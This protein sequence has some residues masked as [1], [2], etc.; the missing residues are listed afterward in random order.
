MA[1]VKVAV[2]VRPLSKKEEETEAAFILDVNENVLSIVNLKV[3]GP[4]TEGDRNRQRVRNFTFDYCYLSA[5]KSR[6]D[7]ASQE[8][9]YQDLGTEILDASFAGYNACLFAYGQTGSGKTYTMMG[10]KDDLGLIPRICDGL[11]S[12][13]DDFAEDI[14]CQIEVSY[15]EIYNERV[16]D[17]L[18]PEDLSQYTLKVRE[19]PKDGPYVQDLSKHLVG[20]HTSVRDLIERGNVNRTTA[21]THMHDASSRSHAIFTINF[22]QARL[23]DNMPSEVVSKINLVDLA[24]SE[25]ADPNYSKGRLTE[26]ANINKSLVTLGNCISALGSNELLKASNSLSAAS[27]ESLAMAEENYTASGLPR[28]PGYIPYRNSV[29]TWLLKDSLGGNSKTIMISTVSPSSTYFNETMS[30]LRY[31]RRAKHIVNKPK[32]NEDQNVRLIRE[33]RAEIDSLKALLSCASLSSSQASLFQDKNINEILHENEQKVDRLTEAWVEK[34]REAASIMQECNVGIRR[35]NV[36]VIVESDLPHL[37]GMDDDL[38]STGIILY[39][40]KEG[41]TT[42]GRE[43]ADEEQD[44]VLCGPAIEQK[45]CTIENN[46][47]TVTLCPCEGALSAVN[48][49][50]VNQPIQLTQGAVV[51]FGKTNMYRFNHP[52]QAAKLRERR[53]SIQSNPEQRVTRKNS[54]TLKVPSSALNEESRQRSMSF[55]FTRDGNLIEEK[56]HNS[57]ADASFNNFDSALSPIMMYNSGDDVYMEVYENLGLERQ[58]KI[59]VEKLDETRKKLAELQE[60]QR[61]AEE[62]HQ[63]R[64][65]K[66]RRIY[67]SHQEMIEKQKK[68]LERLRSEHAQAKEEAEKDLKR[69]REMLLEEKAKGEAKLKEELQILK[70][71]LTKKAMTSAIDACVLPKVVAMDSEMSQHLTELDVDRKRV[72]QLELLYTQSQKAAAAQLHEK[73][74]T[75]ERKQDEQS[76]AIACAE[77][78]LADIENITF[79]WQRFSSRNSLE[80][81]VEEIGSFSGESSCSN[82]DRV[83]PIGGRSDSD[84]NSG[85]LLNVNNCNNSNKPLPSGNSKI[86]E[87]HTSSPGQNSKYHKKQN[88]K[89]TERNARMPVKNQSTPVKN[90]RTLKKSDQQIS[91]KLNLATGVKKDNVRKLSP[92]RLKSSLHDRKSPSPPIKRTSPNV[93][94]KNIRST[95]PNEKLAMSRSKSN[96]S[97][98]NSKTGKQDSVF[99]RLYKSQTPKF[100]YLKKKDRPLY[101]RDW[102][103]P[104]DRSQEYHQ[105]QLRKGL[106]P[107]NTTPSPVG[108]RQSLSPERRTPEINSAP[109]KFNCPPKISENTSTTSKSIPSSKVGSNSP[110]TPRNKHSSKTSPSYDARKFSKSSKD[111]RNKHIVTERNPITSPS[112]AV[113]SS[114]NNELKTESKTRRKQI[115]VSP[116]KKVCVDYVKPKIT[117]PKAITPLNM[118][119]RKKKHSESFYVSMK[120][121]LLKSIPKGINPV[122]CSDY[123]ETERQPA[124]GCSK[125]MEDVTLQGLQVPYSDGSDEHDFKEEQNVPSGESSVVDDFPD[126]LDN[127]EELYEEPDAN[128][129]TEAFSYDDGNESKYLNGENM[130]VNGMESDISCDSLDNEDTIL[131][132]DNTIVTI[133]PSNLTSP[134][135]KTVDPCEFQNNFDI[136]GAILDIP[137]DNALIHP[138]SVNHAIQDNAVGIEDISMDLVIHEDLKRKS[139]LEHCGGSESDDESTSENT[140]PAKKLRKRQKKCRRSES[141]CQSSDTENEERFDRNLNKLTKKEMEIQGEKDNSSESSSDTSVK[142]SD[143]GIHSDLEGSLNLSGVGGHLSDSFNCDLLVTKDVLSSEDI[144]PLNEDKP[145]LTSKETPHDTEQLNENMEKNDNEETC[146]KLTNSPSLVVNMIQ[147]KQGADTCEDQYTED[148]DSDSSSGDSMEGADYYVNAGVL[149]NRPLAD[150]KEEVQSSENDNT[151]DTT[152][153]TSPFS[154]AD[155]DSPDENK[156]YN[157]HDKRIDV[158]ECSSTDASE[159]LISEGVDI[160]STESSSTEEDC[161][162]NDPVEQ[163]SAIDQQPNIVTSS[164]LLTEQNEIENN[165]DSEIEKNC[166]TESD[167]AQLVIGVVDNHHALENNPKHILDAENNFDIVNKLE[168]AIEPLSELEFNSTTDDQKK[169]SLNLQN[170]EHAPAQNDLQLNENDSSMSKEPV[171]DVFEPGQSSEDVEYASVLNPQKKLL[172]VGLQNSSNESESVDELPCIEFRLIGQNYAIANAQLKMISLLLGTKSTIYSS[173]ESSSPERM[174]SPR[175]VPTPPEKNISAVLKENHNPYKG[176]FVD[177]IT[178]TAVQAETVKANNLPQ[179]LALISTIDTAQNPVMSHVVPV[180]HNIGDVI[181]SADMIDSGQPDFI[182]DQPGIVENFDPAFNI[183]EDS[184]DGTRFPPDGT[185]DVYSENS[186]KITKVSTFEI[187]T[188]TEEE[189]NFQGLCTSANEKQLPEN[190]PSKIDYGIK[191]SYGTQTELIP[192]DKSTDIIDA[193]PEFVTD[194]RDVADPGVSVEIQTDL[195][196]NKVGISVPD[197]DKT[198]NSLCDK[199]IKNVL[200]LMVSVATL[201]TMDNSNDVKH[202]G[203]FTECNDLYQQQPSKSVCDT[204]TSTDSVNDSREK[205]ANTRS[206]E[207]MLLENQMKDAETQYENSFQNCT[208]IYETI[209]QPGDVHVLTN[210]DHVPDIDRSNDNLHQSLKPVD[211]NIQQKVPESKENDILPLKESVAMSTQTDNDLKQSAVCQTD[212]SGPSPLDESKSPH[213]LSIHQLSMG[214]QTDNDQNMLQYEE[215]SLLLLNPSN[216][217]DLKTPTYS[218]SGIQVDDLKDLISVGTSYQNG[219]LSNNDIS[220]LIDQEIQTD[221]IPSEVNVDINDQT[222]K[223]SL[224]ES[225][226]EEEF[227]GGESDNTSDYQPLEGDSEDSP[228]KS[229]DASLENDDLMFLERIKEMK[230]KAQQVASR[231]QRLTSDLR[232]SNMTDS[233]D[234][235]DHSAEDNPEEDEELKTG[236][237][238]AQERIT[239]SDSEIP[240]TGSKEGEDTKVSKLGFIR[241]NKMDKQVV[242]TQLPELI[243]TDNELLERNLSVLTPA[244]KTNIDIPSQCEQLEDSIGQCSNKDESDKGNR[245]SRKKVDKSLSAECQIEDLQETNDILLDNSEKDADTAALEFAKFK[246][247]L[248]EQYVQQNMVLSE[249]KSFYQQLKEEQEE[250]EQLSKS[251]SDKKQFLLGIE[252]LPDTAEVT[253]RHKGDVGNHEITR[254][255]NEL[256]II[257]SGNISMDFEEET[258]A[259]LSENKETDEGTKCHMNPIKEEELACETIDT[260]KVISHAIMQNGFMKLPTNYT[261]SQ[262]SEI[263]DKSEPKDEN[264]V[265]QPFSSQLCVSSKNDSENNA[266]PDSQSPVEAEEPSPIVEYEQNYRMQEIE[267]SDQESDYEQETIPTHGY[268]FYLK[269]GNRHQQSYSQFPVDQKVVV[270]LPNYGVNFDLDESDEDL[271]ALRKS[272]A[273]VERILEETSSPDSDLEDSAVEPELVALMNEIENDHISVELAKRKRDPPTLTDDQLS[274]DALKVPVS[275][276]LSSNSLP[277]QSSDIRKHD[278]NEM[279]G[280]RLDPQNMRINLKPLSPVR[281]DWLTESVLENGKYKTFNLSHKYTITEPFEI[282]GVKSVEMIEQENS[283][284]LT[285]TGRSAIHIKPSPSESEISTPKH[286]IEIKHPASLTVENVQEMAGLPTKFLCKSPSQLEPVTDVE[287]LSDIQDELSKSTENVHHR[288]TQIRELEDCEKVIHSRTISDR[289]SNGVSH[290]HHRSI[291]NG[292]R[293]SHVSDAADSSTQTNVSCKNASSDFQDESTEVDQALNSTDGDHYYIGIASP[294]NLLDRHD[295]SV[296][297]MEARMM[298]GIGETDAWLRFLENDNSVNDWTHLKKPTYLEKSPNSSNQKHRK[299]IQRP[300]TSNGHYSIVVPERNHLRSNS[301]NSGLDLSPVGSLRQPSRQLEY[302]Q[303]LRKDV[304]KATSQTE[305]ASE[306]SGIDELLAEYQRTR[307]QSQMEISKAKEKLKQQTNKE[308][309]R[310]KDEMKYLRDIENLTSEARVRAEDCIRDERKRILL[311][312]RQL[313]RIKDWSHRRTSSEQNVELAVNHRNGES[314]RYGNKSRDY[315]HQTRLNRTWHGY[316]QPLPNNHVTAVRRESFSPDH[317]SIASSGYSYSPPSTDRSHTRSSLSIGSDNYR[318]SPVSDGKSGSP[319]I[320]H[321]SRFDFYHSSFSTDEEISPRFSYEFSRSSATYREADISTNTLNNA[322]IKMMADPML[323]EAR[324]KESLERIKRYEKS[325]NSLHGHSDRHHPRSREHEHHHNGKRHQRSVEGTQ[326]PHRRSHTYDEQI[327]R[328]RQESQQSPEPSYNYR[329]YPVEDGHRYRGYSSFASPVITGDSEWEF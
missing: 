116:P 277:L 90:N 253:S 69:M 187:G 183:W 172:Q 247:M 44:I 194:I 204:S 43:D 55:S 209:D 39:H 195:T 313:L 49:I 178:E 269:D 12:R 118:T 106:P 48:G 169:D 225:E 140:Q 20:D 145:V 275:Y 88:I 268:H 107:S 89:T 202:I 293:S 279:D 136:N 56:E 200:P 182:E 298:H 256:Q 319:N 62:E 304:V 221:P 45:H 237:M 128:T 303:K 134:E 244:T 154:S 111:D 84:S 10:S 236:F 54:I 320:S 15:L 124:I 110:R 175:R 164:L 98:N 135:I 201:T 127:D 297:L 11:C 300:H 53:A 114:K 4:A 287:I 218:D 160:D 133:I 274:D 33:L 176:D 227:I 329:N 252:S 143:T 240:Q 254:F 267:E 21:A 105:S 96:E 77:T 153:D 82:L 18:A 271:R 181:N 206:L 61:V 171:K 155:E 6:P 108:G 83:S 263:S 157:L 235:L 34:W 302:L 50:D 197:I 207:N 211:S 35:E 85:S 257:P 233:M 27:M 131:P 137:Q 71:E 19:H 173:D 94:K 60:K 138:D 215:K 321:R 159:S 31:A 125:S 5:D 250:E 93:Q 57:S 315:G 121:R 144:Q 219:N 210:E 126:S 46:G 189:S 102:V 220:Y 80:S 288:K 260:S 52:A 280:Q 76:Q 248:C 65:E 163:T 312:E 64:E 38:L 151:V 72:A 104:P 294:G 14:T 255:R 59:E 307:E 324:Y 1:N 120:D 168:G 246:L 295:T 17:L 327:L 66:M 241:L 28:K 112:N 281:P 73:E 70:D 2:R 132:M 249:V 158:K 177:D 174:D 91:H 32:V 270:N 63:E 139:S 180:E 162:E 214:V 192:V 92:A 328:V 251:M 311:E 26:G 30:T 130:M 29:L 276:K 142:H 167:K 326:T 316:D 325:R 308:K 229:E 196:H 25:R 262:H 203:S 216:E 119:P 310:L 265:I 292:H 40:L 150:I 13:V 37:L 283:D 282:D 213:S 75:L 146:N 309:Q 242:Y 100:Q 141:P 24:G 223:K 148:S 318:G 129:Y 58:H 186:S 79:P 166:D 284:V 278:D 97:L 36:G 230:E 113:D 179:N 7:Y 95:T 231:A 226:S 193:P 78:K 234:S 115:I 224:T 228:I 217:I 51:L 264:N 296:E 306:N 41:N 258:A 101:G 245:K 22:T 314:R 208:E 286:N 190:I 259:S 261:S 285:F 232:Q 8:L 68:T 305:T 99:S 109:I 184:K 87:K 205:Y 198:S 170:T 185:V 222:V 3:D 191:A 123:I 239:D 122:D 212:I 199:G 289:V 243:I 117:K 238:D 291:I 290:N 9:V 161:F 322:K 317:S 81:L 165:V 266:T 301:A 147:E 188:Q 103:E 16:R 86:K 156:T 67:Q 23:K 152:T 47:G 74:R 149:V 273:D 299:D 272:H 42:I 323:V